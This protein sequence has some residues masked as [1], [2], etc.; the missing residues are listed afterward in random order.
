MTGD[1]V[2][3]GILKESVFFEPH[4]RSEMEFLD[5]GFGRGP[6]Q[7]ISKIFGEE[8]MVTIPSPVLIQRNEEQVLPFALADDLVAM[9][10]SRD[11]ITELGGEPVQDRCA[12]EKR[13]DL[14]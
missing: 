8:V 6:S 13:P 10:N 7:S 11:L 3:Y 1:R 12:K 9:L 5:F 4:T 2:A 14:F